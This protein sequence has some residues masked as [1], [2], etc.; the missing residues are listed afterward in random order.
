MFIPKRYGES[1]IERCPFCDK[2]AL[3]KN[4]Q[5]IPTCTVHKSIELHDLKC[6]CGETLDIMEGKF[7]VFFNC[8]K[9]GNMNLRRTLEIN[10]EAIGDALGKTNKIR[11][12][13]ENRREEEKYS[14]EPHHQIVRSDDPRY[15]D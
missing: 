7:G 3:I 10:S 5:G 13:P 11:K 1:R 8:M 15:F 9:C 4:S 6:A 14:S 2:Q 12:Q